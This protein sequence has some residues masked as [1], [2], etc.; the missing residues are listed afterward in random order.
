MNTVIHTESK[1]DVPLIEVVN[2]SDGNSPSCIKHVGGESTV[3]VV[4]QKEKRKEDDILYDINNII[5]NMPI[6]NNIQIK[7]GEGREE[8]QSSFKELLM[9][10]I[11][12]LIL[13]YMI[14][15][16][17]FNSY[18]QPLIILLTVPLG[19]IGVYFGLLFFNLPISM[20]VLLGL[21][22]LSGILV[23]NGIVLID[24]IN[25]LANQEPDLRKCCIIACKNRLR[26]ILMTALTTIFGLLPLLFG[27]EGGSMAQPMAVTVFFGLLASTLLT[28]F[29]VPALYLL[30]RRADSCS[31]DKLLFAL[32]KNWINKVIDKVCGRLK[33]Y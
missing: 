21:I 27:G 9:A 19:F 32:M 4:I 13:V 20:M 14:I 25:Q 28:L 24:K 2:I 3:S 29:V 33:N 31:Q 23:N 15:A 12:S 1:I 5:S 11:L 17:E 7:T 18:L 16:S 30:S 8:M 26:P 10:L 22:L 6:P